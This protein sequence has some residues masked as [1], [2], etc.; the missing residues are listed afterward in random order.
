M[1]FLC[2]HVCVCAHLLSRVRLFATPWTVAHRASLSMGFSQE[3]H[4]SGLPFSPPRDLPD[5]GIEPTSPASSALQADSPPGKPC[6]PFIRLY[7]GPLPCVMV[8][9][10]KS[11]KGTLHICLYAHLTM[12]FFLL[13]IQLL[14][15][16]MLRT[17]PKLSGSK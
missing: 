14:G 16:L 2:V 6:H 3:V 7:C 9:I 13:V 8:K 5:P 12:S 15:H 1:L 11:I 10:R 4:W 17:I